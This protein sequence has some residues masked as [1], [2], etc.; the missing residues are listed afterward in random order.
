MEQL[1]LRGLTELHL[2]GQ[3]FESS[4]S[5]PLHLSERP[6][7][8]ASH[9]SPSFATIA[10][11]R[12]M[13]LS[14]AIPPSIQRALIEHYTKVIQRDYPLLSREQESRLLGYENPLRW[15]MVNAHH[16]IHSH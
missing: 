6:V 4:K 2:Y 11:H 16:P 13:D 7:P 1:L 8:R 14:S 12:K 15:S 10:D 3:S 9:V 5:S